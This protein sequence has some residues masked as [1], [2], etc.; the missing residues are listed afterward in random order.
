MPD[1]VLRGGLLCD[2]TGAPPRRADVVVDAGRVLSVDARGVRADR[3]LDV[4]GLVVAPGFIDVHT[5]YDA[6]LTWDPLLT[7]SCWHGVT[8]VVV[9]NCGFALA[10]CAPERRERLLR[11]LE[12][13]EGMPWAALRDGV[14][15]SWESVPEYLAMLRARP[16]ALN[17]GVLLGHSS[18]RIHVLGDEAYA[19]PATDDEVSAMASLVREGMRA[20]ALGFATSASTGHVGEGGRPVPS[21]AATRDELRALVHAM[22][23]GGQGILE[24]TP[25]TFP[26]AADELAFLQELAAASGRPVSFSAVLDLP[27]RDGVWEPLFAAVRDGHARG[28]RVFPQVSCRPMRFDFDLEVGCASLD[29]IPAWRRFRAASGLRARLDLLRDS[30]FRA[31]VR[32]AA[33]GRPESPSRRRWDALV[34]EESGQA[35][36][37]RLLGRSLQDVAR[38]RGG[39]A[40]DALLDLAAEDGLAARFSMVLMNDDEQR[41]AAL[42]REPE[43]L[44]ALSDAGAHVAILCD[45]GYATHLLGHW[46][47]ER[48]VFTLEEAVRRLSSMP[49]D[50]YGIPGRGRLVPGAVADVTCFD[51]TRVAMRPPERVRDLPGG[52]TRYVARAEGIEH[53]LVAGREVVCGG[54]PT[55]ELPGTLLVPGAPAGA[56]A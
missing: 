32:A 35:Q 44:I 51:P 54:E 17:V 41:V 13:V 3:E 10:P 21:R 45:A 29:A 55:G 49:A 42:L 31:E 18:L 7:P 26:I 48:G 40:I 43:S 34:L 30:G 12:H 5:H 14:E 38:E 37:A 2:G 56:A 6:Q 19:R 4:G 8:S 39:D 33:L 25:Q 11:M 15:W 9:G 50:V 27:D 1:L 46:T 20:G 16:R 22:A 23:E 47:R 28:A 24:I 53:V 36:H 52:A